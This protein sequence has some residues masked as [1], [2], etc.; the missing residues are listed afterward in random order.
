MKNINIDKKNLVFAGL[1]KN[2][3]SSLQKNLEFISKFNTESTEY[4]LRFIIVE[5]NSTDGTKEYLK[6]INL[7]FLE[8][9]TEDDLDDRFQFRTE[10]IANCRNLILNKLKNEQSSKDFVYIP[11]DL[12]I[13]IFKYQDIHDFHFQLNN[14]IENKNYDAYFPFSFPYYYDIHALRSKGWNLHNPWEMVKKVNKFIFI[15]KFFT[16][17][18]YVYRFQKKYNIKKEL[19][20]VESAFGGIG[21]YKMNNSLLEISDYQIDIDLGNTSCEHLRFNSFFKNKAIVSKW[22]VPAPK[23]HIEYKILSLK[24]KVFYILTS[25]INDLK[26][27][28]T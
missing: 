19:I 23:E 5:S 1:A 14:F 17:Y 4:N 24:G 6:Q 25:I 8:I 7:E 9:I 11:I 3:L 15:G 26:S 21:F 27:L 18:F 2:C 28:T 12:D 20:N 16:R 10:K 13:E 22:K